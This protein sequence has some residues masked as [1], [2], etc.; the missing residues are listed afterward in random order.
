MPI[1]KYTASADTTIVNAYFPNSLTRAV[2]SNMGAADSLEMFSIYISGS[3]TQKARILVKFPITEISASRASGSLPASGSVNFIFNLYNVEHPETLSTRYYASVRPISSSW[4]EGFGLDLENYYDIGLSGS[5]GYGANW[6]FCT[7]SPSPTTWGQDGADYF[8]GYE[9]TFYF[10]NGTEDLRVDVTKIV[11]DQIAGVIPN[12]GLLISLSGAYEDGTNQVTYYTKR[13]SARSSEY[14][15]KKPSIEAQWRSVINDNRGYFYYATPNLSTSDN[16]QNI[17]FYNRVNG[18]LKDLPSSVI[19]LVSIYNESNQLLT[20][21]IPSEKV[22]TGVYKAIVNIT[23]SSEEYLSD[24]WYSG[25]TA[26][27]T[28]SINAN[29][30]QFDDS[31]TLKEYVI[32]MVN[33]KASYKQTEKPAIRIFAREKDWSPTIYKIANEELNSLTFNN[34]YYKIVRIV[35][36]K[37]IIDY[38][39]SP[40]EYTLCS[41]DKNGN[42]FDLD[43]SMLQS[44]YA[45]AIKLMLVNGDIKTEFKNSFRFKVE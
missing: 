42:Y 4:D 17:Y 28:G 14:F 7:N 19:P 15:Y 22:I 16:N 35:D 43:M 5:T 39:I 11:E 23:G 1:T 31:S 44:G 45:Y 24:V 41:Y 25:S 33:L 12:N 26:F 18:V 38:G 3:E 13:F 34:L 20:S 36:N 40:I 2:Y 10:D 9:K 30:R 29:I 32:S 27:Y 21:S 6:K 37:T 8:N